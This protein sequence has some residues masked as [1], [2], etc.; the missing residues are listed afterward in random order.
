M[1]AGKLVTFCRPLRGG[2][3]ARP[4]LRFYAARPD[5]A[6]T[7]VAGPARPVRWGC[8]DGRGVSISGHFSPIPTVLPRFRLPLSSLAPPL[9]A[10]TPP[11]VLAAASRRPP[12]R[13]GAAG[14]T[15]PRPGVRAITGA[16]SAP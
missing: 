3:P 6:W 10:L 15:P 9:E 4:C 5:W 1:D 11:E 8:R 7:Y 2:R 16:W 14:P 12:A 13:P